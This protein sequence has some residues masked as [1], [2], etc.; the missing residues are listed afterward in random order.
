MDQGTLVT[1][2]HDPQ[3]GARIFHLEHAHGQF[4]IP[5]QY[6][7]PLEAL[8]WLE[9]LLKATTDAATMLAGDARESGA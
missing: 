2:D 6:E 5:A 3:Q 7:E 1:T 4:V 8:A 9:D